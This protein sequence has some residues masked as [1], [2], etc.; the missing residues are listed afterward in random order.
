MGKKINPLE[1]LSVLANIATIAGFIK[2]LF[3]L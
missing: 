2:T 3:S 1:L